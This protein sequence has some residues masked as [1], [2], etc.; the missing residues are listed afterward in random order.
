[1]LVA[2]AILVAG[3]ADLRGMSQSWRSKYFF[4]SVTF[5]E[6]EQVWYSCHGKFEA[7]YSS[8]GYQDQLRKA[9]KK[10]AKRT[11]KRL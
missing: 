3:K 8:C 5:S 1:M 9:K 11:S 4:L 7:D 6:R 2:A 10:V